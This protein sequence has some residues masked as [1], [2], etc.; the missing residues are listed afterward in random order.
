MASDNRAAHFTGQGEHFALDDPGKDSPLDFGRG[1]E[2]TLEAWVQL[3]GIS[4]GQQ[5]YIVGK[6]RHMRPGY[7]ADNQNYALRLRGME[8][9]GAD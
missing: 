9:A 3:E 5:I 4:D 6:G 8:G 2:I 1:D 7:E